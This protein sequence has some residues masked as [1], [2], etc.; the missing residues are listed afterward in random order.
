M[1]YITSY[2]KKKNLPSSVVDS[3]DLQ[4]GGKSWPLRKWFTNLLVHSNL[5]QQL[6]L[7]FKC[8]AYYTLKALKSL[9]IVFYKKDQPGLLNSHFLWL[10]TSSVAFLAFSQLPGSQPQMTALNSSGPHAPFYIEIHF[11]YLPALCP[12]QSHLAFVFSS[13]FTSLG[14]SDRPLRLQHVTWAPV[15]YY[16]YCSLLLY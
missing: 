3:H 5:S 10:Q 4:A 11:H 7:S 1:Y 9:L 12:I 8:K 2:K 13:N 15:L 14:K 6:D 16:Q